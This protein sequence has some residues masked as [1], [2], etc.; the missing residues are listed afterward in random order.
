MG[1]GSRSRSVKTDGRIAAAR[2]IFLQQ[3]PWQPVH[4]SSQLG[5]RQQIQIES[6][7]VIFPI[8]YLSRFCSQF[9]KST[10]G[11][12]QDVEVGRKHFW[13]FE[14]PWKHDLKH[15]KQQYVAVCGT[16]TTQS[17]PIHPTSGRLTL[18]KRMNFRK[19]SNSATFIRRWFIL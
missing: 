1:R 14:V 12:F 15:D 19:S 11:H 18:P 10:Q 3:L 5:R 6:N 7:F 17:H 16:D 2:R 9:R 8:L 13:N 4:F